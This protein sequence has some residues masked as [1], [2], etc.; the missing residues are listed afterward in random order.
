MGI[1]ILSWAYKRL[2][3]EPFLVIFWNLKSVVPTFKQ[4][5]VANI[6]NYDNILSNKLALSTYLDI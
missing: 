2:Y 6:S 4:L 5:Y 3:T 1:C